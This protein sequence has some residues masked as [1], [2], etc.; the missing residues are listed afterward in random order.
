MHFLKESQADEYY[1]DSQGYPR[2]YNNL[3][4]GSLKFKY[5][6]NSYN[7]NY[8]LLIQ[9]YCD[10]RYD[11]IYNIW[12]LEIRNL[13]NLPKLIINLLKSKCNT[14]HTLALNLISQLDPNIKYS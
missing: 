4:E 2:L 8:I 12:Y 10:N 6:Y 3:N 13:L 14:Q 5:D 1:I 11:N 7:K 9:N